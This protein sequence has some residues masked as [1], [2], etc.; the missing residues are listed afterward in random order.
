MNNP[1]LQQI[2]ELITDGERFRA[3]CRMAAESGVRLPKGVDRALV[4][5]FADQ[6]RASKF[7]ESI[8]PALAQQENKK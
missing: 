3:L 1:D 7:V 4:C 5:K 2:G 8:E 6:Y